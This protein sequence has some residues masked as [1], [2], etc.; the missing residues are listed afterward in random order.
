VAPEGGAAM[1]PQTIET[2]IEAYL[3]Q[4]RSRLRRPPA[5]PRRQRLAPCLATSRKASRSRA[6]FEEI[7]YEVNTFLNVASMINRLGKV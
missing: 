2:T 5:S 6:T 4:S 1:N 7:A 3:T